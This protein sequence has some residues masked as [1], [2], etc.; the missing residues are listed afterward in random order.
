MSPNGA[1]ITDCL[2]QVREGQK[3][4]ADRLVP[5]VYRE[6]KKVAVSSMRGEKPGGREARE[7]GDV[8]PVGRLVEDA[9]FGQVRD[10]EGQEARTQVLGDLPRRRVGHVAVSFRRGRA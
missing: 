2:R 9:V 3:D 7:P 6:L 5:L 1:D 8:I 4:A 10:R